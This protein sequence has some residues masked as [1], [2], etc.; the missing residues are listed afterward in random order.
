MAG[1]FVRERMFRVGRHLP[2]A[3]VAPVPWSPLDAL[4]RIARP[5]FRPGAPKSDVQDGIEVHYPRFFSLPGVLKRADGFFM[6]LGAWPTLRRL[7]R[8]GRLDVIDAHFGYPDGYAASLLARWLGVPFTVTVRGT[9][10]RHARA[11]ALRKRLARALTRAARVFSVS[12]SLRRV[13]L[14]VGLAADRVRVVGN[15]VDCERFAPVDR[16]AARRELGLPEHARVL[17]SVCGLVPRKGVHRVIDALP[18]LRATYPDLVYLVVGGA[19]PEGDMTAAL[20]ARAH[21]LGLDDRVRFQGPVAP[22]KLALPLSA[23]DVFVLATAN[24]GWANVF[25]EAMA[26]GLPVITT[27]V[28]GNAE[29][30]CDPSLGRIVP[31]GDADALVE[32]LRE[33]LALP[34]DRAAIRRYAEANA[35]NGR[36]AVLVEELTA[37]ATRAPT[38]AASVAR[39][40]DHRAVAR[41]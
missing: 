20:T 34:W 40:T 4:V 33:A 9:E 35:W 6:A 11:P 22:A 17:I 26:C 18:A 1:V 19:S 27:D 8:A 41:S 37:A 39:A 2:L 31:F 23:A 7:R 3:V 16:A 21:A 24:E 28:G 12:D 10:A 36:V 29:V 14:D 30:V 25:L 32:A 38:A 13:A 5:S 15:G